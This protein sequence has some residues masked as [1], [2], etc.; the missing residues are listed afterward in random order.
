M[1]KSARAHKQG[2]SQQVMLKEAYQPT[3]AL[4]DSHGRAEKFKWLISQA[5]EE[6]SLGRFLLGTLL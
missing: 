5:Q 6:R 1:I 4:C 3:S 2:S